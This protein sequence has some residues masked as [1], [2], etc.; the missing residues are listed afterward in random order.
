MRYNQTCQSVTTPPPPHGGPPPLAQGRLSADS[1]RAEECRF[2][3]RTGMRAAHQGEQGFL[4]CTT[5]TRTDRK[6]ALVHQH[7][8]LPRSDSIFVEKKQSVF[9][10]KTQKHAQTVR[11]PVSGASLKCEPPIR[12]SKA[13]F[14]RK[15]KAFSL[16]YH[17]LFL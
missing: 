5:K 11:M 6:N 13:F 7:R 16:L 1:D 2:R 14:L 17:T 15:R 9:L 12:A 3:V 10:Y 4:L 8:E